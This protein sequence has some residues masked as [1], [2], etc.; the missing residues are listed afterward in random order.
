MGAPVAFFTAKSTAPEPELVRTVT[1]R[2]FGP[3]QAG[4]AKSNEITAQHRAS[5]IG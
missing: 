3:P 1:K 4:K 5:S 2:E